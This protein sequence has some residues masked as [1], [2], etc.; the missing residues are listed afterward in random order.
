LSSGF[1]VKKILKFLYIAGGVGAIFGIAIVKYLLDLGRQKE[2]KKFDE[3]EEE[4]SEY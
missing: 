2:S 4:E 1:A 3:E